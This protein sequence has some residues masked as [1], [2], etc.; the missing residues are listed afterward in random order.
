MANAYLGEVEVELGG[1][2]CRLCLPWKALAEIKTTLGEDALATLENVSDVEKLAKIL[3]I[4]LRKYNPEMTAEA[5]IELSP[6]IMTVTTA[7]NLALTYALFGG[8][9]PEKQ[10]ESEAK[11]DD[12]KKK[13]G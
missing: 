10:P 8:E 3:E 12:G 4:G 5:I 2:T 7:L 6:P 11:E 1:K 13:T 9:T